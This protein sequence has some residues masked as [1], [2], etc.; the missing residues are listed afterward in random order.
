MKTHD[1][2]LQKLQ[3]IWYKFILS[4][5]KLVK[6]CWWLLLHRQDSCWSRPCHQYK[7]TIRAWNQDKPCT[8][9]SGWLSRAWPAHHI[10]MSL[11]VPPWWGSSTYW[12]VT[13]P[14]SFATTNHGVGWSR[15]SAGLAVL[16]ITACCTSAQWVWEGKAWCL[17][18]RCW[19]AHRAE[20]PSSHQAVACCFSQLPPIR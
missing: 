13:A 8:A 12:W 10:Q 4:W 17:L 1:H 19:L 11:C 6:K 14:H 16:S 3:L 9:G 18:I 2:V 15:A 20:N 7:A 5:L